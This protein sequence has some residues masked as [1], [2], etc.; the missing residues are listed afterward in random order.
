MKSDRIIIIG[1]GMSGLA[2]VMIHQ[3]NVSGGYLRTNAGMTNP[4]RTPHLSEL[5]AARFA[6]P[7]RCYYCASADHKEQKR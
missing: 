3:R 4:R 1:A 2:M 7:C 6:F 5:R